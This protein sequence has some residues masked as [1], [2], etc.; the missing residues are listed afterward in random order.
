M[1]MQIEL[2][3]EKTQELPIS[4]AKPYKLI[5]DMKYMQNFRH[6]PPLSP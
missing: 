5:L 6:V 3:S 4:N 2:A 1:L